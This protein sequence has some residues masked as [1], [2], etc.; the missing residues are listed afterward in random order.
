ML[1][2]VMRFYD[3]TCNGYDIRSLVEQFDAKPS[4]IRRLLRRDLD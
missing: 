4:K 1:T 2:E 3:L